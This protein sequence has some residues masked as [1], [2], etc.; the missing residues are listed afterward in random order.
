MIG[1]FENIN[2]KTGYPA[3]NQ[4]TISQIRTLFL[5]GSSLTFASS[6]LF[7]TRSQWIAGL[8]AETIF[9][10]RNLIEVEDQSEETSYIKSRSD[11]TY[12]G[13]KGKYVYILKA[14]YVKEY[15]DHIEDYSGRN[16][17]RVFL[18]DV[19]GNIAG[20][21]NGSAVRGLDIELLQIEKKKY[22]TGE[23]N[24]TQIKMV[25]SDP[26]ELNKVSSMNW[27]PNL[28][29]M[30]HVTLSAISGSG[31][32]VQ[33]TIKDSVF[34]LAIDNLYLDDITLTDNAGGIT[35]LMLTEKG[36]GIY[37]ITASD[38]L[39]YGSIAINSDRYYG[40][41]NYYVNQDTVILNNFEWESQNKFQADVRLSGDLSLYT[42][43][44]LAD[45]AITDDIEG[46][47]TITGVTE[48]STGRYEFEVTED[49]TT[50]SIAID[51][52]TVTGSTEYAVQIE[53]TFQNFST[54]DPANI[55]FQIV[56]AI[57]GAE[58]PGMTDADFTITD[59]NN[60][61]LEI[62]TLTEGAQAYYSLDLDE[63]RTI[64]EVVLADDLYYGTGAY[65]YSGVSVVNGGASGTT[66]FVDSNAD[67]LADG[68]SKTIAG[69]ATIVS[70][71]TGFT[72][73]AQQLRKVSGGLTAV[74]IRCSANYWKNSKH[75]KLRFKFQTQNAGTSGDRFTS[76]YIDNQTIN[77]YT[78]L[79]EPTT[80][81]YEIIETTSFLVP[82]GTYYIE[83]MWAINKLNMIITI[84]EIELIEV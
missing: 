1:S 25:L 73:N 37:M 41:G 31:A 59:D 6:T 11:Y 78:E 51:D 9:A 10:L 64:G 50:G 21:L 76:L 38:S 83:L 43:L 53:V 84:D 57:T 39:S 7:E 22:G 3:R 79:I 30:V 66:D 52:G 17:L 2:V 20:N 77:L 45:F 28:L 34:G 65:D 26:D 48:V 13:K 29:S 19:N 74:N 82:S 14:P 12:R 33:F 16:D 46:T 23:V 5:T 44:L 55:T 68:F 80:G 81:Y 69:T 60:G 32:T 24:W 54:A 18:A 8:K 40:S 49:L 62:D 63:A 61:E 56:T 75:Y 70:S 72:G 4:A 36:D 58:V 42:G 47:A 71:M 27:N 35:M 15:H 67:G